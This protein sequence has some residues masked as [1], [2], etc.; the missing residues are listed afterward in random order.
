MPKQWSIVKIARESVTTEKVSLDKL[1]PQLIVDRIQSYIKLHSLQADDRI[2][3]ESQLMEMFAVSR[4][5]LREAIK[6][7]HT[8]GILR[9][10]RGVGTFVASSGN[11]FGESFKQDRKKLL[12]DIA[13]F[14]LIVEPSLMPFVLEK[15]TKDEL[16][17]LLLLCS[18]M[19]ASIA[20]NQDYYQQDVAFHTLLMQASG[21]SV[22]IQLI[23]IIEQAI[24]LFMEATDRALRSETIATHRA[25]AKAIVDGRADL[26]SAAMRQHLEYN[27]LEF[28][29]E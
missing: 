1:L 11:V 3:P 18:Q 26:A 20:E 21:N 5:T 28:S 16:D 6:I 29:K 4:S 10:E 7:L 23:P 27:L 17:H 22:I 9:I 13:Y 12:L 15:I 8:Q 19:E 2:P 14:R 24:A 25:I